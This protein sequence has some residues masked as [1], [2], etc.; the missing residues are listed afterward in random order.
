MFLGPQH[1]QAADRFHESTLQRRLYGLHSLDWGVTR[2]TI[3]AEALSRGEFT[4]RAFGAVFPDGTC[5]EVPDTDQAPP[6]LPLPVSSTAESLE[7]FVGL[8]LR[9]PDIPT[10]GPRGGSTEAE[11]RFLERHVTL[12][13]ELEPGFSEEIVFAQPNLRFLLSGDD[14]RA[15]QILRVARLKRSLSRSFVV[16]EDFIPACLTTEASPRLGALLNNITA[17]VS[18]RVAELAREHQGRIQ[19]RNFSPEDQLQI[20]HLFILNGALPWLRHVSELPR[21]SPADLFQGLSVLAGQLTTLA[22]EGFN[23]RELPLYVH[24]E[25][26]ERFLQLERR[27]LPL[28]DLVISRSSNLIPL[29]RPQKFIWK[30]AI[31]RDVLET[32]RFV[33]AVRGEKSN[34]LAEWFPANAKIASDE[35]I[36]DIVAG[37]LPGVPMSHLPHPP[38]SISVQADAQYFRVQTSGPLWDQIKRREQLCIYSPRFGG[39]D[40]GIEL[41]AVKE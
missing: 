23:V 13:D 2:L 28:I 35:Q 10:V 8:P 18:R 24:V 37:I 38:G 4:V 3:D 22:P 27:L 26:G 19:Q 34:R 7:I 40:L 14:Q 5:V 1:F 31:R 17:N 32:F 16:D 12:P 15:Y 21:I 11:T 36:Q 9:R 39:G 41:Y 6:P 33:L 20:W 29:E 30:A 25:A